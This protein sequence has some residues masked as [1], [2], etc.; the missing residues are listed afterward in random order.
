MNSKHH[1]DVYN[2]TKKNLEEETTFMLTRNRRNF[3]LKQLQGYFKVG[4]NFFF[5]NIHLFNANTFPV[6]FLLCESSRQ[7][8]CRFQS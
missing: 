6:D 4:N 5:H 1:G 8:L 7:K 2:V 3:T